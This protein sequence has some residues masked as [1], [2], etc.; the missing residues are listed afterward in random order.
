MPASRPPPAPDVPRDPDVPDVPAVPVVPEVPVVA[1]VP[2]VPEVPVV[3]DV[4][5][6]W[7][8]CWGSPWR[9]AGDV[10]GT[11]VVGV[12]VEDA[13]GA[14]A[15]V[16]DALVVWLEVE[17]ALE[18]PPLLAVWWSRLALAAGIGAN[19]I[20]QHAPAATT[21]RASA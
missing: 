8:P 5:D 7:P 18:A 9:R 16:V 11:E 14:D 13:G 19:A 10:A 15:P 4:P 21:T 2:L 1:E 6:A 17:V 3:P 12:V 20:A